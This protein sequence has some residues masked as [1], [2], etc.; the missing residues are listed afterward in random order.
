MNREE[1]IAKLKRIDENVFF[2][3]SIETGA[4]ASTIIVGASALLLCDL[5]HKSATKDVDVLKVEQSIRNIMFE[6]RDF[7]SQCSIFSQ[8]L[9]YNF[10]DRLVKIDIETYVI[11][12][13]VPSIEDM[14]VMKLYR[15]ERPDIEDLTAPEFLERLNWDQLDHL[16]HSPY[17]AAASRIADQSDDRELKNLFFN[18]CEYEKGWRK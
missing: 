12:V 16:V 17:E 5:S 8:C 13:Y 1:L 15:W 2:S 3:G 9:P 4:R 6:D 14:T 10:E 18:Y 11:D 7:N